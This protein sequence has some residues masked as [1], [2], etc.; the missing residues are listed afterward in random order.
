MPHPQLFLLLRLLSP[1]SA[2]QSHESESL[3]GKNEVFLHGSADNGLHKM[4]KQV[5]TWRFDLSNVKP[6]I[7]VL[8]KDVGWIKLQKP[9]KSYEDTIRTI[10]ITI[11]FLNHVKK[12]PDISA[13][14]MWDNLSKNKEFRLL[15]KH[16]IGS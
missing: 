14:S 1:I 7:S 4:F 9:R 11:H 6:E 15:R 10:L 16:A 2:A 12:N 3:D 5:T 13:K 8:P